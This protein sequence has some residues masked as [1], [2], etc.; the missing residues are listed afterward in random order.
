MMEITIPTKEELK[1]MT[2]VKQRERRKQLMA[3]PLEWLIENPLCPDCRPG[4]NYICCIPCRGIARYEE[5]ELEK[6]F[7][8]DEIKE[9]KS[10]LVGPNSFLGENGCIL[11]RKLRAEICLRYMCNF[12][13][14][15]T[16]KRSS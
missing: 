8:E 6:R 10:M 5:G 4:I 13:A 9:I 7:S 1:T 11:P 12:R 14:K 15:Q 2:R 3:M 16:I